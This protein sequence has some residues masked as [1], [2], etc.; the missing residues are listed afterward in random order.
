MYL[1]ACQ[2]LDTVGDS[3]LCCCVC[4]KSFERDL[5][6]LCV[7]SASLIFIK[8]QVYVFS[9]KLDFY[10]YANIC[11]LQL[12]FLSTC[13]CMSLQQLGFLSVR[14]CMS[15]HQLGFLSPCKRMSLQHLGFL[16]TYMKCRSLQLSD[17]YSDFRRANK[18][19]AKRLRTV[20]FAY[21]SR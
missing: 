10:Q 9:C 16:S 18:I 21:S 5:T 4:V 17:L 7:D 6:P 11:L 3:G 15:L 13:K 2:V 12:R 8:M 14:K 19:V 1:L 20:G